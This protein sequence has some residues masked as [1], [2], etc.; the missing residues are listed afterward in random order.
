MLIERRFNLIQSDADLIAAC[1]ALNTLLLT[2]ERLVKSAHP[3][4]KSLGTLL[5]RSA[6]LRLAQQIYKSAASSWIGWRCLYAGRPVA[7]ADH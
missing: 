4:E 5:A 6:V 3:I 7:P 2:V 1:G